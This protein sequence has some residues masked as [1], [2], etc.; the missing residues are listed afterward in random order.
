M[1]ERV[2]RGR[3]LAGPV[4]PSPDALRASTS[5]QAEEVKKESSVR[6]ITAA[7]GVQRHHAAGHRLERNAAE[8]RGADH[9][10]ELFRPRKLADRFHQ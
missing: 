1:R 2:G 8:A 10:G 5:P 6:K 4:Q 3:N 9:L 7:T